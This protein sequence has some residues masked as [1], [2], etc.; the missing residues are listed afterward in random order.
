M[1]MLI[2]SKKGAAA[3]VVL[4]VFVGSASWWLLLTSGAA[5]LQTQLTPVRMRWINC[6]SGLIILLFGLAALLSR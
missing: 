2:G 4:G 1:A 6:V 5:A 3:I